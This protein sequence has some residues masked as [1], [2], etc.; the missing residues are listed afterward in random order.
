MICSS[1]NLDFFMPELSL[2]NRT[3]L[4]FPVVLKT[5]VSLVLFISN[6]GSEFA[7]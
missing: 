7:V 6:L 1:V 2:G 3:L 5:G 4:T